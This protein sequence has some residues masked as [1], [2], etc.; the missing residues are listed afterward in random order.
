MP[1]GG[2]ERRAPR[3]RRGAVPIFLPF[4]RRGGRR[5]N[6]VGCLTYIV[7][8][9]LIA[10]VISFSLHSSSDGDSSSIPDS[11]TNREKVESS[12]SFDSDCIVDEEGWFD[13]ISGTA[14]ELK[15]FYKKT[16]I[17]PYIVIHSYDSSLTTDDEKTEYAQTWYDE[18]ISNET[19]L[20]YMYFAEQ[21]ANSVGYMLCI[22][23]KQIGNVMDSEADNIFWSY[24][25][26]Y[27]YSDNSTDKLFINA[28]NDT[29][30][31]IMKKTRSGSD[32]AFA[33]VIA[34]ILIIIFCFAIYFYKL[35]NKRE[36]EK[37]KETQD[38][39][40]ADLDKMAEDIADKYQD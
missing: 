29:A 13:D 30:D 6:N 28:F 24:I 2:G 39:L 18:H 34:I 26:E 20:L 8:F 32:V 7:V 14:S 25:D 21:D 15:H 22:H 37:A 40:N 19:S 27:W 33:V 16:G 9:I 12:A 11:T 31:R 38:I 4:G 17:Q 35:R 10:I 3:R 5:V 1:G 23:G 36:A